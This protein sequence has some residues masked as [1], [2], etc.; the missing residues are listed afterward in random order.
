MRQLGLSYFLISNIPSLSGVNFSDI[1]S[2]YSG[3]L[4]FASQQVPALC[5]YVY[6]YANFGI[7]YYKNLQDQLLTTFFLLQVFKY[8]FCPRWAQLS[9]QQMEPPVDS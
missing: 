8:T 2:S 3:D 7:V 4:W 9:Y 6:F 5:L 1:I